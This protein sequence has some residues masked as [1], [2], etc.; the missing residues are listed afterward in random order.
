[1]KDYALTYLLLTAV[2]VGAIAGR[3]PESDVQIISLLLYSLV[4]VQHNKGWGVRRRLHTAR[5]AIKSTGRA[6]Q[7]KTLERAIKRP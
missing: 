3:L 2:I 7:R 5:P 6:T 1:M 4:V